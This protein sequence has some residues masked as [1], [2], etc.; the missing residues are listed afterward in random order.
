MRE[1]PPFCDDA[2]T[3]FGSSGSLRDWK[4]SPPATMYQSL[5]LTPSRLMFRDGPQY[6]KLSCVPPQML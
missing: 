1:I 4:P 2:Y 3:T 6:E 5:V